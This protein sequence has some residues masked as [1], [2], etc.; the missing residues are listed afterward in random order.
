[1]ESTIDSI[2]LAAADGR[3]L[4][5]GDR[6]AGAEGWPFDRSRLRSMLANEADMSFKR[7]SE[8][9]YDFLRI[10]RGHRVLDLG[11]GR[12]FYL[13]FTRE[14]YPEA[15]VIGL[16]LDRPLLRT[17]LSRV[18]GS[19]VV[20][21]SAY[22]LPFADESFD[23]IIFSEVI[24]HI[25]DDARAMREIVRVLAPGGVLALTTPN[26]DYPL[27]W[28]PINKVLERVADT[29]IQHGPLAGIWAN[30]VRL[31]SMEG[32]IRLVGDAGL[33]VMET[34]CLT[35]HCFPFI[36]NMVYGVGKELLEAGALPPSIASAADRFETT[37]RGGSWLNPVRIGLA[38]FNLVD[39]LDDLHPPSPDRSFLI[40]AIRARKPAVAGAR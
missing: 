24:E 2:R 36:H 31:Y 12:G 8:A 23:R 19:R 32:V 34:R 10:D 39:G 17:A 30:H 5:H 38:A 9:V 11:S 22:D 26:A 15:D 3:A 20:N 13:R 37:S 25:P 16:E 14:L 40:T 35:H 28:D 27:A 21:A 4:S 18:P 6:D 33:E 1:M 29:H 7:R